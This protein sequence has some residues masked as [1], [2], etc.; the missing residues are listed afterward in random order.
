MMGAITPVPTLTTAPTFS[1]TGNVNC[2]VVCTLEFLDSTGAYV[3]A[4]VNSFPPFVRSIDTTTGSFGIYLDGVDAL[5][6][7]YRPEEF[8][9]GKIT[10]TLTE[11]IL[12]AA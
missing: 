10:V 1:H 9:D 12:S 2:E 6:V 5:S 8:F 4:V 7:S 11:S 3:Q